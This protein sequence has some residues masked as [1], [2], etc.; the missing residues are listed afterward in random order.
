MSRRRE[1]ALRAAAP[2]WVAVMLGVV[3]T[4]CGDG[5]TSPSNEEPPPGPL[6]VAG[7]YPATGGLREDG[8]R[9]ERGYRLA[10]QMLNEAGGLGGREVRLILR[11]D[12]SDPQAAAEIYREL[13]ATDSIHLLIGP[14]A[15]SIT[16]AVAPVAEA[17]ARPLIAGLAS[18]SAIW[19]GKN[20]QWIVQML[21][22]A[23][24]NL[25]GAAIVAAQKG[26]ETVAMAY[27]D[28]RFPISAAEGVRTAVA[29]HGLRLVM[30]EKYAP[31]G[32]DHAA[33][34][35]RA[36]DLDADLFLGGGY[37][38]DAIAFTLAAAEAGYAPMLMSWA[39]GPAEPSFPTTVGN[40]ARCLI[41]NTP[42]L[43]TLGTSG[44]LADNATF[45]QRFNQTYGEPPGYTAAA[46]FGVVDLLAQAV[47]ASL[48]ETGEIRDASIRDFL[49]RATTSTVLGPYGVVGLGDPNSGSQRLLVRL[50]IQWQD[51]GQGGF[52]QRVVY[53]PSMAEAEACVAG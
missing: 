50:Q 3:A 26:V 19:K 30:D 16:D 29:E 13:A 22:A 4:G 14:Y 36:R 49:F 5:A 32:A 7:T 46:A 21:N 9:M 1:G 17:A 33:L 45:V 42:W 52:A 44:L 12:G 31:G 38:E 23:R 53:P 6:T 47:N 15:S 48:T 24:D 10:I 2:W 27:E 43:P 34:S 8:A 28:S 11:D 20:R 39:V 51:D 41:G 25:S 18:S 35:A 40:L 37:T